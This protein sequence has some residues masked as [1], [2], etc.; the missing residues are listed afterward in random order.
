MGLCSA[1]V[2]STSGCH[3]PGSEIQLS[4]HPKRDLVVHALLH[5]AAIAP[6]DVALLLA[7]PPIS[8]VLVLVGDAICPSRPAVF[9]MLGSV[10][11]GALRVPA[12]A[13]YPSHPSR[14]AVFGV[15]G[16]VRPGALRWVSQSSF[17][18]CSFVCSR[19]S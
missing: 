11:P 14:P 19:P 12:V 3:T 13:G 16:S 7:R 9:G 10:R 1:E 17:S 18:P 5:H 6:L 15:L 2:T 4:V 8:R